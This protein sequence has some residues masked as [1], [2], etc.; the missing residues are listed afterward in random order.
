MSALAISSFALP[1]LLKKDQ[2]NANSINSLKVN[3]SNENIR[4]AKSSDSKK[5]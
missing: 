4:I 2:F 5:I 1:N 3:L